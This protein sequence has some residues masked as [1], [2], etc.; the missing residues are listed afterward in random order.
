MECVGEDSGVIKWGDSFHKSELTGLLQSMHEVMS[1][2][3]LSV[4]WTVTESI[5]CMGNDLGI[6][7]QEDGNIF[8]CY[9]LS[10]IR[11]FAKSSSGFLYI[12]LD[13]YENEVTEI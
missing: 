10:V 11:R 4:R 5:N 2:T 3:F 12:P 8:G 6:S 7:R 1:V 13:V 9:C